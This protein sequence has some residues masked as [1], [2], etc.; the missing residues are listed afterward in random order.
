MSAQRGHEMRKFL[1][2]ISALVVLLIVIV[3]VFTSLDSISRINREMEKEEERVTLQLVDYMKESLSETAAT[4]SNP[5]LMEGILNP[6]LLY[7]RDISDQLKLLQFLTEVQRAQFAADYLAYVSGGMVLSS[8]TKEGVEITE[9]PTEMPADEFEVLEELGGRQGTFVVVF[10]PTDLSP[11]AEDEFVSLAVDRTKQ[12]EAMRDFYADEKSD[13][14]TRQIIIGI[15]AVAVAAL[16]TTLGVYFLT[17]RYITAPIEK[18]ST[19]AHSIMEGTF[20]GQ[21][22]VVEESDYAD[23]QRLLQSGK[24]LMEKMEEAQGDD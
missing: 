9:F 22:E 5:E 14:I 19:D 1:I 7:S 2:A 4:G 10:Q 6:E 16:L 3:I 12:F 18:L 11:L 15:V 24:V 8:S 20:R 21:V 23:I 17:R 13:L